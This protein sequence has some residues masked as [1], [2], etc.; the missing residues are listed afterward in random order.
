MKWAILFMLMFPA[1]ANDWAD[2]RQD[3]RVCAET[4]ASSFAYY[5][6]TDRAY[7]RALNPVWEA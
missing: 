7:N 3:Y 6:C 5:V 2:L 1:S 4:S